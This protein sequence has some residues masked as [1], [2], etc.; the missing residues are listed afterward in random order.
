MRLAEALAE[1]KALDAR[2][3]SIEGRLRANARIQE[4]DAVSEDPERLFALLDS[5]AEELRT[6]MVRIARTNRETV[7]DGRPLAD[8]IAERDVSVRR[9]NILSGVADRAS[10]RIE[11]RSADDVRVVPV[12]DVVARKHE[13][14]A[15]A[16]RIRG[17]DARK[18]LEARLTRLEERLH[19]SARV[20]EGLEPDESPDALYAMLE[21]AAAELVEIVSRISRTNV[22]TVVEG[23]ILADWIAERDVSWRR[24]RVLQSA[25]RAAAPSYDRHG[26]PGSVR[27]VTTFSTARRHAELDALALRINAI[28]ARIQQAN[29]ETEL[30]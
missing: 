6:L 20:Q 7:V 19:A 11:R 23:R 12:I 30:L 5:T 21:K 29:W 25:L 2:L 3:S 10:E 8:W 15:L 28:D 18:E 24:L 16:A 1:R 4:G 22:E 13:A 17:I 27:S 26:G 14:D 9:F